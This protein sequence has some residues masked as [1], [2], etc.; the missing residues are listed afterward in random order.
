M[1]KKKED[2]K[3]EFTFPVLP[4][5]LRCACKLKLIQ[6]DKIVLTPHNP[7]FRILPKKLVAL[8][9]SM[10]QIGMIVPPIVIKNKKGQYEL[11]TLIDGNRRRTAAVLGQVSFL[12]CLVYEG[13]ADPD[14]IYAQVNDGK[15]TKTH[16]SAERL[17]I[18]LD[19]PNAIPEKSKLLFVYYENLFGRELL[20]LL[21][22]RGKADRYLSLSCE[23]ALYIARRE[24]S[25]E[26]PLKNSDWMRAIAMWL[27]T[28]EAQQ[29]SRRHMEMA[30]SA[31]FLKMLIET[32]EKPPGKKVAP[33]PRSPK[34]PNP[35]KKK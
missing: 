24:D 16:K 13:D 32:N 1:R 28:H 19:N 31:T 14:V 7:R 17:S 22:S 26:D 4:K 35:K 15:I 9:L 27:I 2:P 11:V 29:F 25:Q 21:A 3:E 18:Y 33:K 20:K 34:G 6:V 10:Q 12:E 23:I 8:A 30:N 5:T